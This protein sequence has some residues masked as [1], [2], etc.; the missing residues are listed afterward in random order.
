MAKTPQHFPGLRCV[1]PPLGGGA[2]PSCQHR[3][4]RGCTWLHGDIVRFASLVWLQ[5]EG[6]HSRCWPTC[7][8]QRRVRQMAPG[9]PGSIAQHGED[10]GH[11]KTRALGSGRRCHRLHRK[12]NYGAPI[13]SRP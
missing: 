3:L 12:L 5:R 8:P 1:R 9:A 6:Q 13:L 4:P 7:S 2:L 11:A 10:Q